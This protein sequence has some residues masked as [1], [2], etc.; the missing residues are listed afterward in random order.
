M[1]LDFIPKKQFKRLAAGCTTG[2]LLSLQPLAAQVL[3]KDIAP[4]ASA[5][6][7]KD[8][9]MVGSTLY[10]TAETAATGRELYKSNG[11]E[12]GTVLVKDIWPGSGGSGFDGTGLAEF[13]AV[14]NTLYFAA[15]T[16][17]TGYELW[18][19]DGTA[20]GTVMVKD[21]YPGI[22]SA[23]PNAWAVHY[24]GLYFAASNGTQGHELWKI[25]V[26]KPGPDGVINQVSAVNALVPDGS[27]SASPDG[28][29]TTETGPR[30]TLH[31]N[32][33]ADHLAVQLN[34]PATDLSSAV[35]DLTGKSFL[36]NAH[37]V[38]GP[39]Q[40]QVDVSSLKPGLYLLRIATPR[41][42]QSLRFVKQ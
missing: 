28:Q 27:R 41:G 15:K 8:F 30:A 11:T 18:K 25:S 12:A 42:R 20:A 26:P 10:F 7:P 4:G 35:V 38:T 13:A 6:K 32:P 34:A 17:T 31:P 24:G 29:G 22:G 40:L 37:Q 9:E 3:V 23:Y 5:S 36:R 33:A 19:S 1:Q 14:G 16:S 21:I 39:H 2:L